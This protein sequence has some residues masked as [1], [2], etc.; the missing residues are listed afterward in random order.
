MKSHYDLKGNTFNGYELILTCQH[1]IE[2][3]N[4]SAHSQ[5]HLQFA[6]TNAGTK[7]CKRACLFSNAFFCRPE[8]Q[9]QVSAKIEN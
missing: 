3:V 8:K 9:N 5:A 4:A 1:F 6:Q 2:V 7:N